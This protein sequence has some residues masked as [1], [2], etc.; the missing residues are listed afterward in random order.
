MRDG[1]DDEGSSG[2]A[3]KEKYFV[4]HPPTKQA[5][6]NLTPL[7]KKFKKKKLNVIF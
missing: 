3:G 1:D 7:K 2:L 5:D 4:V 6:R